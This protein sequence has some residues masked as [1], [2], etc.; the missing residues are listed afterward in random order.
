MNNTWKWVLVIS[1]KVYVA[2]KRKMLH[3]V[4]VGLDL[5]IP[6]SRPLTFPG[7]QSKNG[8][9]AR[10]LI[11]LGFSREEKKRKMEIKAIVTS[12][13]TKSK[14]ASRSQFVTDK[15]HCVAGPLILFWYFKKNIDKKTFFFTLSSLIYLTRDYRPSTARELNDL[16]FKRRPL[17]SL[18]FHARIVFIWK[19]FKSLV[20]PAWIF[21]LHRYAISD[22]MHQRKYTF[23]V[24]FLAELSRT[25]RAAEHHG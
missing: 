8:Y 6:S 5:S 22:S 9:R 3:D 23:F 14:K 15:K 13:S 17:I 18:V 10:W 19:K 4:T 24:S 16:I 11:E 21:W 20:F 7:G 2:W 1:S 12:W 25:K